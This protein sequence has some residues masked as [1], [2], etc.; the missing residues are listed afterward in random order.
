MKNKHLVLLFLGILGIGLITR[1]FNCWRTNDLQANLFKQ[2]EA[3]IR[4]LSIIS[5][6]T[7]ELVQHDHLWTVATGDENLML[8]DSVIRPVL[9]TLLQIESSALLKTQK[10]DTLGFRAADAVTVVCYSAKIPRVEQFRLGKMVTVNG[11][12]ST[13]VAIEGHEQY[14]LAKGDLKKHMKID[15]KNLEKKRC[16]LA[17]TSGVFRATVI[18]GTDTTVWQRVAFSP[19][20]SLQIWLNNFYTLTTNAPEADFFDVER[21]ESTSAGKVVFSSENEDRQWIFHLFFAA[22][23]VIP[24]D[25][26][27]IRKV[28]DFKP[29]YV[30]AGDNLPGAYFALSDT[31]GVR[32]VMIKQ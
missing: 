17:D 29:Q 3:D 24:D 26:A 1:H 19:E 15:L 32:E 5:G 13:W 27:S 2:H 30:I 6:D 9:E 20:D 12:L 28:R 23:P 25:P 21:D 22:S 31:A 7:L 8:P 18:F 4:K 16:F 14:Y 10:P 11:V